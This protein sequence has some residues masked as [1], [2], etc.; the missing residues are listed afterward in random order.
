M[1]ALGGEVERE[2]ERALLAAEI[3]IGNQPNAR[4]AIGALT[5][6]SAF[7]IIV[8]VSPHDGHV[9]ANGKRIAKVAAI[10]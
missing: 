7:K 9:I 6:G 3:V 5:D 4:L 8:S 10:L 1:T 2:Q